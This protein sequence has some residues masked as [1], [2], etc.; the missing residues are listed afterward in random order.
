LIQNLPISGTG[1]LVSPITG[2]AAAGPG[3]GHLITQIA[4]VS[5]AVTDLFYDTFT[6]NVGEMNLDNT[7]TEM[8]LQDNALG[9]TGQMNVQNQPK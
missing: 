7:I 9:E 1:G 6:I 2:A 5:D 4:G 3:A 8:I